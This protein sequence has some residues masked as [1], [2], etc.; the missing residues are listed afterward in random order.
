MNKELNLHI[1]DSLFCSLSNKAEQ[2]GVSIEA[3]CVS[4]L[5]G[6]QTFV[7]PSLYMSLGNGEIRAEIQRLLQSKLPTEEVN[8][9]VK[10]LENQVLR[11]IR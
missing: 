7:E 3:L 10:K 11:L 8:R 6:E 2:Q 9:R 5:G 1:P 4:L